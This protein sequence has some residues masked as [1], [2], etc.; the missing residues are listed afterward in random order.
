MYSTHVH[1][2][3][4]SCHTCCMVQ[5]SAAVGCS[6]ISCA[7]TQLSSLVLLPLL[8][9]LQPLNRDNMAD[10]VGQKLPAFWRWTR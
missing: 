6:L 9:L 8:V 10:Y 7:S 4:G 1:V 2:H 5:Q 3:T